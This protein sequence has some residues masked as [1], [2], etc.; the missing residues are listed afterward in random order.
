MD[1]VSLAQLKAALADGRTRVVNV[2]PAQ[3]YRAAH[4]PGTVNIPIDQLPERAATELPDR[5]Q[6]IIAYCGGPT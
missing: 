2:L 1:S 4:I 5:A 6:P 3:V